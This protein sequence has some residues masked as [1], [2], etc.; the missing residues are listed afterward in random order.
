MHT[1]QEKYV[2]PACMDSGRGGVGGTSG[3]LGEWG[4]GWKAGWLVL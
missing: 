2:P 4:G 1:Y 3:G